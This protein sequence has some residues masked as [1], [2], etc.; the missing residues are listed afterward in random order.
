[1]PPPPP[2]GSFDRKNRSNQGISEESQLA[3]NDEAVERE[4]R[5]RTG[6]ERSVVSSV[7]AGFFDDSDKPHQKRMKSS[8]S[9]E[10]DT[11]LQEISAMGAVKNNNDGTVI[12]V[13]GEP[14]GDP[15]RAEAEAEDSVHIPQEEYTDDFEQFLRRERMKEVRNA[16]QN[17]RAPDEQGSHQELIAQ[18]SAVGAD[19]AVKLPE[20]VRTARKSIAESYEQAMGTTGSTDSDSCD[21]DDTWRAKKLG[22]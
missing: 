13:S 20:S 21:D 5:D 22:S 1:M 2:L 3:R 8:G 19:S 11:F 15:G 12:E 10:L 6:G 17:G 4:T 9:N 14:R 7:P 18:I 16:A